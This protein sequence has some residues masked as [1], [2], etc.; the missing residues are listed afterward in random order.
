MRRDPLEYPF[1]VEWSGRQR[2]VSRH[3]PD[4]RV[5][6]TFRS[7]LVSRKA[8]PLVGPVKGTGDW[9]SRLVAVEMAR[10]F[11]ELHADSRIDWSGPFP[12]IVPRGSALHAALKAAAGR[13]AEAAKVRPIPPNSRVSM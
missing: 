1:F 11:N 8:V 5:V 12:V 2:G 10:Q 4:Y 3:Q 7:G 9:Q 6:G 13:R